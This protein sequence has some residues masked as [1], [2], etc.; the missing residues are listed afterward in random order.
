MDAAG[1]WAAPYVGRPA[2]G[3]LPS[4]EIIPGTPDLIRFRPGLKYRPADPVPP[5]DPVIHVTETPKLPPPLPV[6]QP[7]PGLRFQIVPELPPRYDPP[8]PPS[9]LRFT[10]APEKPA[11]L[12]TP[13]AQEGLRFR[14]TP[15]GE[16][17]ATPPVPPVL[18]S[19][20]RYDMGGLDVTVR[21]K[22]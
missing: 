13:P 20:E 18:F 3:E 17:F 9:G 19:E 4:L 5:P 16:R 14:L 6:V 1:I 10:L 12:P 15:T 11:P 7:E 8:P 22:I 2:I 21:R